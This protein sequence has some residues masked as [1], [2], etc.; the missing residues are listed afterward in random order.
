MCQTSGRDR[1]LNRPAGQW[2][3]TRTMLRHTLSKTCH[4]PSGKTVAQGL[5][6]PRTGRRTPDLAQQKQEPPDDAYNRHC[7]QGWAPFRSSVTETRQF[8]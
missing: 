3:H 5:C 1:Q 6:E 4:L 8:Q 7:T 2:G